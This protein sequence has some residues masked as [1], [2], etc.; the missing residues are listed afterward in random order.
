MSLY[1]FEYVKPML[2]IAEAPGGTFT[3]EEEAEVIAILS[4]FRVNQ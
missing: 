1:A 2:V 4:S 3:D